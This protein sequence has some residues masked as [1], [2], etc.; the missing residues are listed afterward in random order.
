M[1]ISTQTEPSVISPATPPSLL[2][3][4]T[5]TVI[6]DK[7]EL[8]PELQRIKE[9]IKSIKIIN[10]ENMT[11]INNIKDNI[12]RLI[13]NDPSKLQ[14]RELQEL[15]E[16][17]I[18]LLLAKYLILTRDK[19]TRLSY[20]FDI[21][22]LFTSLKTSKSMVDNIKKKLNSSKVKG[23]LDKTLYDYDSTKLD[24]YTEK[25]KLILVG[26]LDSNAIRMLNYKNNL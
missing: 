8:I 1:S 17:T 21:E 15:F 11:K 2:R 9:N 4:N 14:D 13:Q 6:Y 19:T 16:D 26:G 25:Q 24:S 5:Y 3:Q 18:V 7:Q 23:T 20:N 10:T 12:I 22:P